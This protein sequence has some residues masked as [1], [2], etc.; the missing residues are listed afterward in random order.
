MSI[1]SSQITQ[2]IYA[3]SN[4]LGNTCLLGH[5]SYLSDGCK[6]F[7]VQYDNAYTLFIYLQLHPSY[8]DYITYNDDK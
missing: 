5:T 2:N 1:I 8:F 7:I 3:A 4:T 6:I